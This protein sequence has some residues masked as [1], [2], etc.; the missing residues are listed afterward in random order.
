MLLIK[1]ICYLETSYVA[2]KNE[3]ASYIMTAVYNPVALWLHALKIDFRM[4]I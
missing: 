1:R 2:D 4:S 3:L